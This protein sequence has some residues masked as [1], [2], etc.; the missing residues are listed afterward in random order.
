MYHFWRQN[1][2]F[3]PALLF[4]VGILFQEEIELSL[5]FYLWICCA[6][7][8]LLVFR[9]LRKQR[10]NLLIPCSFIALGAMCHIKPASNQVSAEAT[11][12]VFQVK[13]EPRI[14][15]KGIL[16]SAES[17]AQKPNEPVMQVQCF[18]KGHY[19]SSP[20][21]SGDIFLVNT[22]ITS[23]KSP[24]NPHSFD[25]AH[26]L[27]RQGIYRQ[28]FLD[29]GSW[30]FVESRMN[31]RALALYSR[32]QIMEIFDQN[33]QDTVNRGIIKA[34]VCG[35]SQELDPDTRSDFASSGTMHM[36]A[37]SG[38]HVGILL[39]ILNLLLSKIQGSWKN[40][41]LILSL[42]TYALFTGLS[43]SVVRACS[44]CSLYL[45]GAMLGRHHNAWNALA[46]ALLVLLISDTNYIFNAG[47]QLSFL[48][49]T[50]ILLSISPMRRPPA[51]WR[52]KIKQ[53][54]L[55]FFKMSLAAQCATLPVSALLF[56]QFPL[57]FLLGNL[58][59]VPLAAPMMY[60][61]ICLLCFYQVPLLSNGILWLL[62][63]AL[64]LC[65]W[66]AEHISSLPNASLQLDTWAMEQSQFLLLLFLAVLG[67]WKLK[68]SRYF[69]Y[70]GALAVAILLASIYAAIR[71]S[72]TNSFILFS[73]KKQN[74]ML[75]ING[76]SASL[77]G[78]NPEMT[79]RERTL[80]PY[81]KAEKLHLI[82][83]LN[84][85]DCKNCKI[86]MDDLCLYRC[87]E[88]IPIIIHNQNIPTIVL[89]E[90]EAEF[91][92][93]ILSD[94][95]N[96]C[97]IVL[98]SNLDWK[99]RKNWLEEAKSRNRIVHDIRSQGAFEIDLWKYSSNMK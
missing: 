99:S 63:Q 61:G 26:Y 75:Y 15:E 71:K 24:L 76:N 16:F 84:V 96:F 50:G 88:R 30:E 14:K 4:I 52:E 11:T 45:V 17:K 56:G 58:L 69:F 12:Y 64:W 38:M 72:S 89:L 5:F 3:R 79:F 9:F 35:Y 28:S 78:E 86:E 97:N 33:I 67:F 65:R 62:N 54:G 59:I 95:L 22:R 98:S 32:K 73:D 21:Q 25:Y 57:Y 70:S 13:S 46:F 23:T 60:L 74:V 20:L 82:Q 94:S 77:L 80:I 49:L 37:V 1:P 18:L 83:E 2:L 55:A 47:F 29:S 36:L 93:Y 81:L 41:L 85:E 48:A 92:P 39:V 66:I 91:Q 43:P 44:M 51:T 40:I 87:S 19:T 27:S 6:L 53:N 8:F 42:W 10:I 34:L 68:T 31:L 90:D 7:G